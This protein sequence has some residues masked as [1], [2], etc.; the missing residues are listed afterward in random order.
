IDEKQQLVRLLDA[1][2]GGPGLTVVIGAEHLNPQLRPFTL[3]ACAY[4][5]GTSTGSVGV[6]GPTRMRDSRAIAAVDGA[7]QAVSPALREPDQ[8]AIIQ[9]PSR[10]TSAMADQ[11]HTPAADATPATDSSEPGEAVVSTDQASDLQRERDDYYD[12]WVRKTAEF[13]NY[14]KRVERERRE[15]TDQAITG[16]LL[17]L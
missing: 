9:I 12:R 11:S 14:R 1:Y 7:G 4:D 6:I 3:I 10:T 15:H 8:I 13:E 2:I 16:F 5:D 17:E